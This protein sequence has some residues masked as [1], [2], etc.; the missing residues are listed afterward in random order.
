MRREIVGD[1][2]INDQRPEAS[3]TAMRKVIDGLTMANSGQPFNY[4]GK[5]MPW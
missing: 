1:K 5:E 4:D 2:A 3:V